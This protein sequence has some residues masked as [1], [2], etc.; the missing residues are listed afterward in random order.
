[1]KKFIG[2]GILPYA[3]RHGSELVFLLGLENRKKDKNKLYS[4]FGG[5]REKNETPSA[6]AYREFVEETMDMM[7]NNAKIKELL[8]NPSVLHISDN[9]YHEYIIKIDFNEDIT[10]TYNRIINMLKKCM[11]YKNKKYL[12]IP[13][14]PVGLLEKT[15]M[16]W[17]TAK[18]IYENKKKMRPIFFKTFSGFYNKVKFDKIKKN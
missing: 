13:S 5:R 10:N 4:D 6:T 14:C 8:K 1:M 2:A 15:E 12:T 11:K 18:E 3:I 9:T 16:C 17:F 7:G